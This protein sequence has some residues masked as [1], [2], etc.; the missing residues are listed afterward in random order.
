MCVLPPPPL[1]VGVF[2]SGESFKGCFVV[3]LLA[4]FGDLFGVDDGAVGVD[5]DDGPGEQ[6]CEGAV[7]EG[8]SVVLAEGGTEG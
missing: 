8:D 6:S 3:G 2:R 4:D 1:A 7:G 5:D